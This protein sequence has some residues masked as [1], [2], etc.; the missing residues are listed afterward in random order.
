MITITEP[1]DRSQYS[2]TVRVSGT[3]HD[4]GGPKSASGA[5]GCSYEVPGAEEYELLEYAYWQSRSDVTSPYVWDGLR[6][7]IVYSFQL[8][9]RMES[10]GD[11]AVSAVA[12]STPFSA[13]DLAPWVV[14]QITKPTVS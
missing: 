1:V 13:R 14:S 5:A 9:A 10:G 4:G 6:N 3:V 11:D 8:T 7:G 2:T 12:Q